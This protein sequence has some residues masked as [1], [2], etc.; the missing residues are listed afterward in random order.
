MLLTASQERYLLAIYELTSKG[1]EVSSSEIADLLGVSRPSV[2]RMLNTLAREKML[3]KER[4]GLVRLTDLGMIYSAGCI[5]R[6]MNLSYKLADSL[7]PK[8]A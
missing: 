4:Y 5:E 3:E 7:W 8:N 2:S 6:V 1:G